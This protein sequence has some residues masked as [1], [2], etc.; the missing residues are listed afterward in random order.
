MSKLTARKIADRM[1]AKSV[2]SAVVNKAIANGSPVI[3]EKRP[4][5]VGD[6]CTVA[7]TYKKETPGTYVYE[8]MDDDCYIPTLYI[9]KGALP[10][11]APK[12]IC[13]KIIA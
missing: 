10:K 6:I 4:A 7:M 1:T 11:G 8:N 13:I 5:A 3:V 9:R 12:S 2:V